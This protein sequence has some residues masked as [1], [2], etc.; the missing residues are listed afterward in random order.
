MAPILQQYPTRRRSLPLHAL[1][2][3]WPRS[4]GWAEPVGIARRR[5]T[6][7]TGLRPAAGAAA[8]RP[9]AAGFGRDRAHHRAT[10]GPRAAAA[11][12]RRRGRTRAG[13]ARGRGGGAVARQRLLPRAAGRTGRGAPLRRLRPHHRTGAE[14]PPALAGRERAAAGGDQDQPGRCRL[15]SRRLRQSRGDAGVARRARHRAGERDAD[16]R[17]EHHRHQ[18]QRVLAHP[19]RVRIPVRHPPPGGDGEG[20]G[21][22]RDARG[23]R[24]Y[25]DPAGADR[26]AGADR[27]R[28][29]QGDTGDPRPLP[30]RRGDHAGAAVA[31]RSSGG[32]DRELPRRAARQHRRRPAAQ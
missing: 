12:G 15:P 30:H 29:D 2:Q 11:A 32:R 28:G 19:Q 7:R 24:P 27:D 3:W 13:A 25:A 20:G 6:A 1:E 4:G 16:R 18:F 23:D 31:R 21:R 8:R 9:A 17:R 10:P 14:L 22:E 5:P 26:G